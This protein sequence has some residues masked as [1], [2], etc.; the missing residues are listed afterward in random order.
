[1]QR[2]AIESLLPEVLQRTAVVPGPLSALLDVIADLHA[3]TE[4]VLAD[5]DRWFSP[6]RAPDDFVPVL[7]SWVDLDPLLPPPGPGG[8]A[9][10][11][12]PG[13]VGRLRELVMA[14]SYLARWRGTSTGLLLFLETASG[15][16]DFTI[17]D[18]VIDGSGR[19][20]AFHLRITAAPQAAPILPLLRRIVELQKPAYVTYEFVIRPE[21]EQ[22][23]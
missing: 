11:P 16:S 18:G 1:M 10:T 19:K 2:S 21:P 12:F 5:V 6:L 8:T 13:G 4:A 7:A 14:S 9:A 15:L 22:G 23:E 17:D 20:R 3:P